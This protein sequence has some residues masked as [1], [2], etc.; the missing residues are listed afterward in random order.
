MLML[1]YTFVKILNYK[2][3]GI[4]VQFLVVVVQ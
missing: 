4:V 2:V 3:I 1:I